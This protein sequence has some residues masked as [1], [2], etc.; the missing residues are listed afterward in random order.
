MW[1]L[2]MQIAFSIDADLDIHLPI[3]P[4]SKGTECLLG[5]GRYVF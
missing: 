1:S 2:L 4:F 3:H 5:I